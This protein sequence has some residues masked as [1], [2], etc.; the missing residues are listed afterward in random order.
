MIFSML[1]QHLVGRTRGADGPRRDDDALRSCRFI[2]HPAKA[3]IQFFGLPGFPPSRERRN[4][5]D[6]AR[7]APEQ[8]RR[9]NCPSGLRA[10][11]LAAHAG[12]FCPQPNVERAPALRRA[13]VPRR[14]CARRPAVV[15][16]PAGCCRFPNRFAATDRPPAARPNCATR[17]GATAKKT[18]EPTI[19]VTRPVLADAVTVRQMAV[20]AVFDNMA[21]S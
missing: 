1:G 5:I 9:A 13:G 15:A 6:P 12:G 18:S 10:D 16:K 8:A 21:P 3:G 4:R 2:R 11:P 20:N 17:V 7:P 14:R 19:S